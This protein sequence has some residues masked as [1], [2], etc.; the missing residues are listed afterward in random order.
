MAT[1]SKDHIDAL[2]DRLFGALERGDLPAYLACYNPDARIWHSR[3]E[4][5]TDLAQNEE[6]EHI[7]FARV[8]NRRFE[9][10]ERHIFD[11][12]FVQEHLVHGVLED[13]S[14]M[15]LPVLFI[16]HLDEEGRFLRVS[17][18]LNS[19]KSPLRGLVQHSV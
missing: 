16:A 17:E 10:L 19:E 4:A 3:D 2:A 6:A 15:R 14:V 5:D 7:F 13:G 12:G 1:F 18:Y 8:A 11:R 9:V